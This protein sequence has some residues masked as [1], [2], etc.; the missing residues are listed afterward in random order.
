[1]ANNAIT[2]SNQFDPAV[3]SERALMAFDTAAKGSLQADLG[4]VNSGYTARGFSAGN[5]S[6]D[7]SGDNQDVLARRAF[8]RGNLSSSLKMGEG[9]RKRAV[10]ANAFNTASNAFGML[11]PTGRST[12]T[13]GALQAPASNYA[14]LAQSFGNQ[15]AQ[16]N[17]AGLIQA[18]A[19]LL[20]GI[21]WPWQKK[22]DSVGPVP[23]I[24]LQ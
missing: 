6:S 15:A 17:P 2:E 10:Q 8:A 7:Q 24:L 18:G 19:G 1:M 14:N 3:E 22:K 9:D 23:S 20:N 21:K 16:N 13:V 12:N 4:D 5:A 11:D